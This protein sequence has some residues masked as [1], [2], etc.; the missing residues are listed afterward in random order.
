MHRINL[1]LLSTLFWAL[2][3]PAPE[4]QLAQSQPFEP[5]RFGDAKASRRSLFPEIEYAAGVTHPDALLGQALGS[6][7]AHHAEIVRG[8]RQWATDSTRSKTVMFGGWGD[9]TCV[10][11]LDDTWEWD[12]R[13]W[14]EVGAGVGEMSGERPQAR[15][16]AAMAFDSGL[17]RIVMYAGRGAERQAHGDLWAWDGKRWRRLDQ[18]R[19]VGSAGRNKP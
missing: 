5:L 1:L 14:R 16:V 12:G 3:A 17:G 18:A 13:Q 4:A 10:A 11:L 9:A 6:R 8:F 15:T 7:L 19:S 2:I